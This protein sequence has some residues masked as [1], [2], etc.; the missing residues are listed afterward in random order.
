MS[1]L[2]KEHPSGRHS[3]V[4]WSD[5]DLEKFPSFP[6][7]RVNEVVLQPGHVLYLPTAWFH[8]IISLGVNYQCNTRS[9]KSA[10]YDDIIHDC[11]F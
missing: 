10:G 2:P 1:L 6:A 7:T 9:G 3:E 8:Y 11:G 4:D 5:P